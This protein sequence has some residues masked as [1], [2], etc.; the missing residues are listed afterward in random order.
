MLFNKVFLK[1]EKEEFNEKKNH[2]SL[3]YVK[4][5]TRKTAWNVDAR[6]RRRE[7]A[8]K[9][10]PATATSVENRRRAESRRRWRGKSSKAR[11]SA[12]RTAPLATRSS[13]SSAP[14]TASTWQSWPKAGSGIRRSWT[15]SVLWSKLKSAAV[16]FFFFLSTTFVWSRA[17]R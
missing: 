10:Q 7:A 2:Y 14:T 15:K 5:N 12:T 13:S 6:S 3:S 11:T 4:E 8:R 9:R 16:I 1:H 17:I